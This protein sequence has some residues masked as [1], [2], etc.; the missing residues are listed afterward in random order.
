MAFVEIEIIC[1]DIAEH[2]HRVEARSADIS[3]F[4]LPT[5]NAV[6]SRSYEPWDTEHIVIDTAGQTVEQ[7][8]T[9][10]Q[11]MLEMVA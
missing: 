1:S 8:V 7:S 10:L 9:R 4:K 6:V 5:W 2:R 11:Q 3:G